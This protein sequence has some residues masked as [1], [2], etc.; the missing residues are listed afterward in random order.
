M[1]FFLLLLGGLAVWGIAASILVVARDG[2]RR[3]PVRSAQNGW[4]DTVNSVHTGPSNPVASQ[5]LP[6]R[7]HVTHRQTR[8]TGHPAGVMLLRPW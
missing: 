4:A 7:A 5:W 3:Q 8:R 6:D 1:T 2:Y